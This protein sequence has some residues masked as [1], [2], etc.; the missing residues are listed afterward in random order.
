MLANTLVVNV[1]SENIKGNGI[2]IILS[3]ALEKMKSEQ[4]ASFSIEKVNLS[5]LERITGISRGKLRG[6]K[7]KGFQDLPHGNTGKSSAN[8]IISGFNGVIDSF[9]TRGVTN[10]CVILQRINELGYSGSMT[11]LK[12]YIAKHKG[13]IPP[14]RQ[15][16]EPQG[17]R[18]RRYTSGP[19]EAYQMDWGFV[20]VESDC[21]HKY[22]V[23]CF[24]MICHHCG[25]K[26]IEFFPNAKQ[27]N[28]F[29]GLIHA[30]KYMGVPAYVLTDNM[31]SVVI[32]R[33][34]YGKPIWQND[35]ENFMK[36]VGFNTKLCK[37]RHPFTKGAVERLVRYVKD[38]FVVGRN[39]SN[40]T[41]LNYEAIK[42]CQD[43]N[44]QYHRCVDCIS[45][46]EH[47][48]KCSAITKNLEMNQEIFFYL[49]P[50]RVI[51]FD[52]FVNYEGR[53]FGVPYSYVGKTCRVCRINDQLY[54]YSS[55]CKRKLATHD[56]TWSRKDSYCPDQYVTQQPEEFPT[57]TVKVAMQE[58][59]LGEIA[60]GFEKFKFDT[61]DI[62]NE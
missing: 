15:I 45:S 51:S 16:V 44:T 19:G 32:R 24:A 50:E 42:W 10:S 46:D 56:V 26:F 36:A 47:K 57:A 34:A 4:G 55:D 6:F 59:A 5:E 48:S 61:E 13:L 39:F 23:A 40:I 38:N 37:P 7:K 28:L 43:T 25:Q 12:R 58:K 9:L 52:G 35:Y 27:E 3:Q 30:F 8:T 22:K 41:E 11:S 53:R 17:N 2:P 33:D 18:G 14:K 62:W 31:K 60:S 21:S 20:D 54:I 49:C 29:I 1:M